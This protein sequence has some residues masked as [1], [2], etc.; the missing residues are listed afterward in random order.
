MT[1]K[2]SYPLSSI[3]TNLDK[4][5]GARI[6][7]LMDSAGVYHSVSIDHRSRDLTMFVS[8]Y[9]TFRFCRM[10]FGLSNSPAVYCRLV[11]KALDY[12]PPGFA[13]AYLN[14]ILVY[15][16]TFEEHI[17]HLRRVVE[18]HAKVG[19][20]L[21]LQKCKIFQTDLDYLGFHVSAGGIGIDDHIF[22]L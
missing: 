16:K 15:S 7:S 11:Q 4:L 2:D 19:M 10:P 6:F 13:L 3:I 22:S 1:I 17:H 14:D 9:G 21:N 20:K 12:L 8:M 5:S 18:L